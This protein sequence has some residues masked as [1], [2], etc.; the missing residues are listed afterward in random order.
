M[1]N[2]PLNV[3][4]I[5]PGT[6]AAIPSGWQRETTLDSQYPKASGAENPATTGGSATHS[7]TSPAHSHTMVS[8]SHTVGTGSAVVSNQRGNDGG[9]SAV[10]N[11]HSHPTTLSGVGG[12]TLSDAVTY[13]SVNN[14]PPYY[15]V[16][17][18]KPSST[19]QPIPSQVITLLDTSTIPTGFSFTDGSASTP[20]LRNRYL[21]GSTPSG[22]AGV[23]DGSTSHQHTIDHTHTTQAHS[24]S[25]TSGSESPAD[26]GT[27]SGSPVAGH[28]THTISLPNA[29]DTTAAYTGS[30]GSADTVEP[31]YYKLLAIQNSSGANKAANIGM[32]ALWLGTT[33]NIPLG[34][35]LCDGTNGTPALTNYYIKIANSSAELDN[36]G[37]SNSHTHTASNSHTHTATGTHTHDTGGSLGSYGTNANGISGGSANQSPIDHYHTVSSVSST[38]ATY[39]STTVQANTTSNEPQYTIAAYIMLTQE[40]GGGALL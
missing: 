26:A 35:S 38:T 1:A 9:S 4:L 20:D 25:G 7:H 34:W 3:I 18:I 21:R 11:P 22:N 24:H 36:T 40:I 32:I 29:N 14:L 10:W 8:H 16:I 31:S 2:I 23:T 5:W 12:G 13:A 30:A 6:H 39:N 27:S 19:P 33:A 37:G 17:F 28:H 15:G